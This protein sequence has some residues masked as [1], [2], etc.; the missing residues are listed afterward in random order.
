MRLPR[1]INSE[2]YQSMILH[3]GKTIVL[4]ISITWIHTELDKWNR[5]FSLFCLDHD[6]ITTEMQTLKKIYDKEVDQ[7]S[8]A[9]EHSL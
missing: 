6:V 4:G 7:D 3:E 8:D 2:L 1:E 5:H 9:P